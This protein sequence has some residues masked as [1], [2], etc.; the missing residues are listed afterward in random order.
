MKLH[1]QKRGYMLKDKEF[2]IVSH[3]NLRDKKLSLLILDYQATTI[4]VP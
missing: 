1:V 3:S 2:S 4:T